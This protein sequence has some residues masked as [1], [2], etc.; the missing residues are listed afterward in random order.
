MRCVTIAPPVQSLAA[1]S[2]STSAH[3]HTFPRSC[4]W[5][6]QH[7]LPSCSSPA[8]THNAAQLR[9]VTRRWAPFELKSYRLNAGAGRWSHRTSPRPIRTSKHERDNHPA[10]C[11]LHANRIT[12]HCVTHAPLAKSQRRAGLVCTCGR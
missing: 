3:W 10:F 5:A 11:N 1:H 4:V 6:V 2:I 7:V 8:C 12:Q 9:V